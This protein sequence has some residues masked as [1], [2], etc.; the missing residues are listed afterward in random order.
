MSTKEQANLVCEEVRKAISSLNN[1]LVSIEEFPDEDEIYVDV[2]PNASNNCIS[3]VCFEFIIRIVKQHNLR[4]FLYT[5]DGI[6]PCV[7]IY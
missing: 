2:F 3:S 4:Y 1:Y 7:T 5:K 6:L